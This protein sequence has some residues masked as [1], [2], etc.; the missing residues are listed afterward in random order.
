MAY[1]EARAGIARAGVTYAG[2]AEPRFTITVGGTAQTANILHDSFVVQRSIR[3][4]AAT[5]RFRC[6][7]FTPTLGQRVEVLGCTPNERLFS[8]AIVR[9]TQRIQ[10]GLTAIYECEAVNDIWLLDFL[11]PYGVMGP[12]G[13]RQ[14]LEYLCTTWA[15]DFRVG[16]VASGL[17]NVP[18]TTFTGSRRPSDIISDWVSTNDGAYWRVRPDRTI[19]VF[20]ASTVPDGNGLTI[21]N[22]T[23]VSAFSEMSDIAQITTQVAS[24][25]QTTTLTSAYRANA[26][27]LSVAECAIFD[28]AGGKVLAPS[29]V[30]IY[31][32][33]SAASGAGT[34]TL[35]TALTTDLAAD[36][37][38][39]YLNIQGDLTAI[40]DLSTALAVTNGTAERWLL[41]PSTTY[42]AATARAIAFLGANNEAASTIRYRTTERRVEPGQAV[43]VN[44]TAPITLAATYVITDVETTIRSGRQTSLRADLWHQVTAVQRD[45]PIW[46]RLF[47]STAPTVGARQAAALPVTTPPGFL[48]GVR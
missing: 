33:V 6:V 38:V 42:A 19:D 5:M 4:A 2:W 12:R 26:S 41:D 43:A 13:L 8:G 18:T 40:S 32:A 47:Y 16:F 9:R 39:A 24:V 48:G 23:A 3:S 22:G 36:T 17:A 1:L 11:Q 34:L 44:I 46:S 15:P 20:T 25:G 27:T 30:G 21:I 37:P 29:G 10:M 7:N 45:L 14:A 28:P 35:T 31:S